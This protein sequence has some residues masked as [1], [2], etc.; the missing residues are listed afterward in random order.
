MQSPVDQVRPCARRVL[1]C[2]RTAR[3]GPR[4]VTGLRDEP[5]HDA[6]E[7]A[8]VVEPFHRELY[9]AVMSSVREKVL[10]DERTDFLHAFGASFGQSSTSMLPRLVRSRTRPVAIG[11]WTLWTVYELSW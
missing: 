10:L 5:R 7:D 4:R 11:S 3:S 6:V 1:A 8:A 2:E 9:E